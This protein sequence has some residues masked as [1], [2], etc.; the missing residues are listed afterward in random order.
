MFSPRFF[1]PVFASLALPFLLEA[2][3]L[4]GAGKIFAGVYE[5]R[6]GNFPAAK[7]HFA[8]AAD[9][10]AN[11]DYA[12]YGLA[13]TCLSQGDYAAAA[14]QFAAVSQDAP[15]RI[16]FAAA[17]NAGILAARQSDYGAAA[18]LFI[19]ALKLDPSSADAKVNLELSQVMSERAA[20]GAEQEL[21]PAEEDG[22]S[23]AEDALFPMLREMD[24]NQWK[25]SDS[26]QRSSGA[27][28]Y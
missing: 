17:Y 20:R 2:C 21:V 9:G 8:A 11:G 18:A 14:G 24:S 28:D 15:E 4:S 10:A 19:Q 27:L 23:T 7:K 25:N 12:A 22:A 1:A 26:E 6:R 13:V 3:A 16:R 5:W